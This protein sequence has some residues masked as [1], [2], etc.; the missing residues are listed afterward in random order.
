MLCRD[1]FLHGGIGGFQG[2]AHKTN[3]E[4]DVL[5]KGRFQLHRL[6]RQQPFALYGHAI[7]QCVFLAVVIVEP[8]AVLL[9]DIVSLYVHGSNGGNYHGIGGVAAETVISGDE[10]GR[11]WRRR[12]E[13]LLQVDVFRR[14]H[15][16]NQVAYGAVGDTGFQVYGPAALNLNLIYGLLIFL[17]VLNLLRRQGRVTAGGEQKRKPPAGISNGTSHQQQG[18]GSDGGDQ[19]EALPGKL[20][21]AYLGLL[22]GFQQFRV[23]AGKA[24]KKLHRC[25]CKPSFFSVL[26]RFF[27]VRCKMYFT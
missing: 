20:S 25:H 26:A 23:Y 13:I 14:G 4:G 11:V 24:P 10:P 17:K 5:F 19:P 12:A 22:C 7:E 27:L 6:F 2:K 15:P 18:Q 8:A 16:E 21:F 9:V 3:Q 1:G